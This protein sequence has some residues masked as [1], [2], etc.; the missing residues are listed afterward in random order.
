MWVRPK[1]TGTTV[2]KF[3]DSTLHDTGCKQLTTSQLSWPG[4]APRFH[5]SGEHSFLVPLRCGRKQTF[6]TFSAFPC[7]DSATKLAPRQWNGPHAFPH[8]HCHQDPS[9][10]QNEGV[11]GKAGTQTPSIPRKENLGLFLTTVWEWSWHLTSR[12]WWSPAMYAWRTQSRR[13]LQD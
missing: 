11:H 2:V 5:A 9:R 7:I 4:K 1:P 8:H 3:H 13:K 10:W 6:L 12:C